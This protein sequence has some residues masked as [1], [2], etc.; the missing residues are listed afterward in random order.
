MLITERDTRKRPRVIVKISFATNCCPCFSI[1]VLPP[2]SVHLFLAFFSLST[3][4]LLPS[5]C[6]LPSLASWR[7][8]VCMYL[9]SFRSQSAF[10]YAS[11]ISFPFAA[12]AVPRW[13]RDKEPSGNNVI[14]LQF[15]INVHVVAF[16]CIPALE[17]FRNTFS[18]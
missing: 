11:F 4:S 18:S 6:L 12:K 17:I 3:F 5:N 9:Y 13:S 14:S 16:C 15:R 7:V 8:S 1:I 10:F 2:L